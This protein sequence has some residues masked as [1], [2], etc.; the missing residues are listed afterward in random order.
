VSI[1]CVLL[2]VDV[3]V[4][5]DVDADVDVDVDVDVDASASSGGGAGLLGS[6]RPLRSA[7]DCAIG[8]IE[9]MIS[10]IASRS[11]TMAGRSTQ[12]M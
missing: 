12:C 3:D 6:S 10:W 1:V 7:S 4:D 2:D 9:L 11:S 5:M 8:S